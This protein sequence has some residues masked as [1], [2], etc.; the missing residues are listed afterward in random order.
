[1]YVL[2]GIVLILSPGACSYT[3]SNKIRYWQLKSKLNHACIQLHVSYSQAVASRKYEAGYKSNPSP[4]HRTL[5]PLGVRNQLFPF[6][7][8]TYVLVNYVVFLS[9][10]LS[11]SFSLFLYL[12][13][14][15]SL[16]IYL[17]LYVSLSLSLALY[18]SISYSILLHYIIQSGFIKLISR[19]IAAK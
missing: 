12:S 19:S 2:C 13:L 17:S 8:V 4:T 10:F 9:L 11:L 18:L 3:Y 5:A 16:S 6:L 1:M 14:S 15:L 7:V